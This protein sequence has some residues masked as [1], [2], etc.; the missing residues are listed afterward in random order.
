M[1]ISDLY[2]HEIAKI[3]PIWQR[4]MT[5]FSRKPSTRKNLDE[6]SRR[7]ADE[8]LKIGL[9]AQVDITPCIVVNPAT[10][11]TGSP[12]IDIVGRVPGTHYAEDGAVLFDHERKRDEVL[13]SRER[14]EDFLGQKGG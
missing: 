1:D 11:E 3:G 13:R 12:V 2:D 14:G 9:V 5:E 6:L 4:L 8:F 7:A 10:M